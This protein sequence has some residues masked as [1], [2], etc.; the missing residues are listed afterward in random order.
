MKIRSLF[1]ALCAL[2]VLAVNSFAVTADEALKGSKAWFKSGKAWNLEFQV[3]VFYAESP[4]I[5]S[6]KGSLL[7]AD[8]DRFRLEIRLLRIKVFL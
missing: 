5:V 8:A 2:G 6:Q 1:I 4:D 3:Q 7:V